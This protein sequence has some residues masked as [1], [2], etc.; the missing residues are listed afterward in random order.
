MTTRIG[1]VAL[2]ALA[3]CGTGAGEADGV[4]QGQQ[5][6]CAAGT[7]TLSGFNWFRLRKEDPGTVTVSN[8]GEELV[9]DL[10]ASGSWLVADWHLYAGTG[11]IPVNKW[12]FEAPGR[13]PYQGNGGK[14][15]SVQVR[16]PLTDL[17]VACGDELDLS[18]HV[19]L[20]QLDWRGRVKAFM[21]AWANWNVNLRANRWG[22]EFSHVVCCDEDPPAPP[23]RDCVWAPWYYAQT[24]DVWPVDE[25]NLGS[26]TYTKAQALEVMALDWYE[27]GG[28][29]SVYLATMTIG[30]RLNEA[31]GVELPQDVQDALDTADAFFDDHADADGRVPYGVYGNTPDGEAMFPTMETL[32]SFGI[33]AAGVPFCAQ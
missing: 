14:E 27:L 25:V 32:Y 23:D 24:P 4:L 28:D 15:D 22:G 10:E 21:R 8:T 26:T 16:I 5:A 29:V 2:L 1:L 6:L 33:G 9:V 13:F 18:A 12:G 17:N 30:A 3:A 31:H 7:E 19:V 11:D 20:V